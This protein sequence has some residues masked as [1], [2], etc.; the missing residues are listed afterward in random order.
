MSK[1]KKGLSLEEKRKRLLEY[2]HETGDFFQ[3]KELE[4]AGPKKGIVAQSV[5]EVIQS[6][7]DDGLV[8][9]DKIGTSNYFWSFPSTTAN[10]K[11]QKLEGL[12]ERVQSQRD[13]KEQ[14]Q[15]AIEQARLGREPSAERDEIL[16]KYYDGLKD[17]KRLEHELKQY[18]DNDPETYRAKEKAAVIAKEAANRWTENIWNLLRYCVDKCN[19]DYREMEKLFNVDTDMD[20]FP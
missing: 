13:K 14:F 5:K 4:K 17:Q 6:L 11:R 7:V 1:S 19:M 16:Q 9:T 18:Q 20:T 3:L 2:L 15:K 10:I 12:Q 8:V